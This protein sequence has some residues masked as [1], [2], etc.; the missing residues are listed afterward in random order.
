[1]PYKKPDDR[2]AQQK[3]YRASE[4][5]RAVRARARAIYNQRGKAV[6]W[7]PDPAPLVNALQNWRTQ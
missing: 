3:R 7:S 2:R 1:M 5:G 4:H 6:K